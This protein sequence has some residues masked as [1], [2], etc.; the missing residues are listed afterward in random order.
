MKTNPPNVAAVN[1]T[2]QN[3]LDAVEETVLDSMDKARDASDKLASKA[4]EAEEELQRKIQSTTATI[5]EFIHEKPLQ[6]AGIAFT[7]GVLATLLL[8]R[9]R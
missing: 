9:N 1:K 2:A 6:A 7:A 5:T 8:S 3:T 4:S